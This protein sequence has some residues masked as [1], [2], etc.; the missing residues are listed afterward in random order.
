MSEFEAVLFWHRLNLQ[1]QDTQMIQDGI[2]VLE[3]KGS[4]FGFFSS[5]AANTF[6]FAICSLIGFRNDRSS[7]WTG[8]GILIFTWAFLVS[9]SRV[10]VG[11]H[12]MGDIMTGAIF[13]LVTGYLT[14]LLA[15]I[16]VTRLR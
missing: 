11:K 13:G 9:M 5:H 4:L 3:K 14:G 1:C 15:R 7:K 16:I 6:G 10:F 8:Y 2:R 12:Y